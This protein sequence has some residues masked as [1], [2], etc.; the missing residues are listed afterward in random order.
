MKQDKIS[1][2]QLMALLWAGVLAPAAEQLPALLLPSAGK[3]A[4]LSVLA[5]A[6]LVLAAGWVLDRRAGRRRRCAKST[7]GSSSNAAPKAKAKA[8]DRKSVV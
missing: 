6:P 2:T 7:N 5:A 1:R 8:T 3:G 4:W